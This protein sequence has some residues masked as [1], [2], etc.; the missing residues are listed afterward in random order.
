M[1]KTKVC[2]YCREE[3]N[4]KA[5][6]CPHCHKKQPD[7]AKWII[8]GIVAFII[9]CVAIGGN[10]DQDNST[11]KFEKTKNKV[12]IIDFTAMDKE[13]VETECNLKKI[14]CSIIEQYSDTAPKGEVFS[15]SVEPQTEVY[16]GDKIKIYISLGK[17]PTNEQKNALKKAES[18]S[19]TMYM[20][21]QRIYEQLTSEY[22]EKFSTEAAQ[23][24]IDNIDVDWN[25]NAL[26]KAKSYQQTM[27]MSKQRIYD[28]LISEYGEKF[29]KEQA[30][31][32]IDHLE[33]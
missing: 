25:A 33:D 11:T 3:I 19:E 10:E 30:Q 5:R 12:T 22:G 27:N 2:K 26:K 18:Y 4:D 15:Q 31:Y 17:E 21:K 1:K 29:T 9:I 8:I 32:A 23:Y 13:L 24:A 14:N 16:E 6:I 28:Q 7:I 20:S